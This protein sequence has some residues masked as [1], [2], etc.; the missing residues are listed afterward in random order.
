MTVG[1]L[2]TVPVAI[3]VVLSTGCRPKEAC[4]IIQHKSIHANA[5]LVFNSSSSLQATVP[6]SCT[7]TKHDYL[8]LLPDEFTRVY[9]RVLN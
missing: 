4:F 5:H 1:H 7:K 3:F 8:W 2:V 9:E 6:A